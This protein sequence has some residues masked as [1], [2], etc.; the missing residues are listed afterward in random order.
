[1]PTYEQLPRTRAPAVLASLEYGFAPRRFTLRHRERLGNVFIINGLYGPGVF[2]SDPEHVRR[3]FAADS[4]AFSSSAANSIMEVVGERSVLV[5]SGAPHKRQRKLL[6]PPLHGARLREFGQAI[7]QI[8]DRH[9]ATLTPGR[10]LRA[11]GLTTAFTLDV[12]VQTVFGASNDDEARVLRSLIRELVRAFWPLFVI[13]PQLKQPW[14]PQWA[15]FLEARERF[16]SWTLA[17]I[18]TARR[19]GERSASVMSLLIEARYDDDS[20]MD[21]GEICDQLVTL[22]LAGHETTAITL[23][24][25]MSR[26][27]QHPEIAQG[28]R[29]ELNR[30]D[31]VSRAPY[32]SA[33]VDETLRLDVVVPDVG[34][35]AKR[36]FALDD[37]LTLRKGQFVMVSIEGLHMD[38]EL[39]AQPLT[40]RPER[41]LARKFAPHEF[42]SFGGGVRRCIGAAF[43]D[44]E[45]KIMLATLLRQTSWTLTRGKPD[46]R[47]RRNVT[48]GPQHGV[49][50]RIA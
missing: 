23:A 37:Q 32:L 31:D 28:L 46:R 41:F 40:F 15:R 26:V 48:M 49:P 30:G 29:E 12:I 47:V 3:I 2:T 20:E 24:N 34:R 19:D 50:I 38:P 16:R 44:F 18:R 17:K 21:D 11:L 45:T 14:F 9:V 27:S 1:M 10:E 43:S 4:D 25:A 5:T 22:L 8:A 42:V 35:I 33:F 36:D 6:A 7:Q 13:V 39:Y